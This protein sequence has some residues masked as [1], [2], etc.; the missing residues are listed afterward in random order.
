M[1]LSQSNRK[2]MVEATLAFLNENAAKWQ[3]IAKIGEVVN[4][5]NDV[6][7]AIDA[8]AGEQLE[9]KVYVGAIK[10]AL[11]RTICEKADIVNDIVEVFAIMNGDKK[12]AQTMADS[13]SDLFKLKNSDMLRRVK[14]IIDVAIQNQTPLVDEYGL[15]AE[16]ITG[17]QADYDHFLEINGQPREYQIKSSVATL[18]LEELFTEASNLLANQLD[19]L[20]KIFKRRDPTFYNGYIKARMVVDY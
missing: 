3:S 17:L 10:V 12:L 7:L 5:L 2:H 15:T 16:Q 11:K 20:L 18:S 19:N 13:A 1:N 4:K 9:A 14:Q 8:A 6:N